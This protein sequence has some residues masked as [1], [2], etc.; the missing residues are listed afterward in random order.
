MRRIKDLIIAHGMLAHAVTDLDEL[1]NLVEQRTLEPPG[2]VLGSAGDLEG[3]REWIARLRRADAKLPIVYLAAGGSTEEEATIRREGVHY[4]G[5]P[6]S[7][8][9]ELPMVL[10]VLLR[11]SPRDAAATRSD[12][13]REG[14]R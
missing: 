5:V 2:V 14:V 13:T 11:S 9:H 1:L 4:F 6:S 12:S 7:L 3:C 10:E 8:A